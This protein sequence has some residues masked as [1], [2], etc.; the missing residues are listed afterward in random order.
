MKKFLRPIG[1]LLIALIVGFEVY[2]KVINPPKVPK[3]KISGTVYV[4]QKGFTINLAGGQYAT[5]TVAMLLPPIQ[6]VGVTSPT[7]P[8]PT[9]FGSLTDEAPIRAI[10][11]N[12]MTDQPEN[13]LITAKGRAKLES[14][15]LSN[16]NSQTDTKVT[17][18]YFTDLAVQ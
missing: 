17:A 15:I 3:M 1:I 12:D 11:T 2:S 13:T 10:I 16:I 14:T 5:L 4:L 7:N 8:P 18:I 9:G 6:S